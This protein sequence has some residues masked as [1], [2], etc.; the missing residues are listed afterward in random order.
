MTEILSDVT[1]ER[2][3][4]LLVG[5][6]QYDTGLR[7]LPGA[8]ADALGHAEWLIDN[9]VPPDHIRLCVSPLDTNRDH[10]R[11][12]ADRLGIVHHRAATER[13]IREV[14]A[15]H[16]PAVPQ[17][18]LLWLT[19]S[20]HGLLPPDQKGELLPFAD[21]LMA[22]ST[23]SLRDYL[24]HNQ[25]YDHIARKV[26]LY[27]ACR[28]T[29]PR[30]HT[31]GW[32]TFPGTA[33]K[34]R[35]RT[36]L[37]SLHATQSGS[38]AY[39]H[40]D[41]GG[42]FT[43]AFLAKLNAAPGWPPDPAAIAHS[44]RDELQG[45][46]LTADTDHWSGAPFRPT[47]PVHRPDSLPTHT[48]ALT[49][50]GAKGKFLTDTRLPYLPPD[51]HH[52]TSPARILA[53]LT[54]PA[55]S[56][57]YQDALRGILLTG[58]AG[59]GKTRTC[60][61]VAR[62]ALDRGWQVFH[63]RQDEGL[64][65]EQLLDS[66]REAVAHRRGS[67]VLLV[68]DYLD[69][70]HSLDL[71]DLATLLHAEAEEG[72][73]IACVAAVRPGA[74][75]DL[76]S[77]G[78]RTLFA[79]VDLRTD[80]TRRQTL[81]RHIF[82]T[83]APKA[84]TA[85]GDTMADLCTTHPVLALLLSLELERLAADGTLDPANPD[86]PRPGA[87]IDWFDRRTREDL[88]PADDVAERLAATAAA[89]TCVHTREAV[90]KSAD[91][92]LRGRLATTAD[93]TTGTPARTAVNGAKVVARLKSHGWLLTAE[94]PDDPDADLLDTIH[95]IVT[96]LFLGETC[97]LDGYTLDPDR[98]GE[99]LDALHPDLRTLRRAVG[100]LNRWGTDLEGDAAD[101]LARA[102][103]TWLGT[104]QADILALLRT[105]PDE[106]A[107]T[108][109]TMISALPWR[110]AVVDHWDTLV[111]PWLAGAEHAHIRAFL[112]DAA[113]NSAAAPAALLR[114]AHDWLTQHIPDDPDAVHLINAL[115]HA[116]TGRPD[117]YEQYVAGPT[118]DWLHHHGLTRQGRIRIHTLLRHTGHRP[119]IVTLAVHTAVEVAH[120][121]RRELADERLLSTL[122]RAPSIPA[123]HRFRLAEATHDWL[124]R[125]AAYEQANYLLR[126]ALDSPQLA[127]TTPIATFA[128]E[129]LHHHGAKPIASFVLHTLLKSPALSPHLAR[130]A[131]AAA[132]TWLAEERNASA[133]TASFVLAP[134]LYK[135]NVEAAPDA[136]AASAAA[137]LAWLEEHPDLPEASFVLIDLLRYQ[138]HAV[139]DP[140]RADVTNTAITK[141]LAWLSSHETP[142]E[143]H[144]LQ[145]LL[146]RRREMTP[147]QRHQAVEQALERM[148]KVPFTELRDS[149]VFRR[150]LPINGLPDA[151]I[152]EALQRAQAW[153]QTHADHP[154]ASFVLAPYL[155]QARLTRNDDALKT[156]VTHALR[157]L[158]THG[159]TPEA[160]YVI[161]K[162]HAVRHTA[163]DE[164]DP[165]TVA[166]LIR[167]HVLRWV[168]A[169]PA[170]GTSARLLAH[171]V[172]DPEEFGDDGPRQALD[173]T[174]AWL[175]AQH[176]T[177]ETSAGENLVLSALL[178]GLTP[179]TA[180]RAE[181]ARHARDRLDLDNP[182]PTDDMVLRALLHEE[183]MTGDLGPEL[184]RA[185]LD[186]MTAHGPTKSD[187]Q[188]LTVLLRQDHLP[189][190]TRTAII[191][192]AM[193]WLG[194][195][196]GL[197][198]P[199][200]LILENL[201]TALQDTPPPHPDVV[202]IALEWLRRNG[203]RAAAKHLLRALADH[204]PAAPHRDEIE[205][206]A[207]RWLTLH[208]DATDDIRTYLTPY[209]PG[210]DQ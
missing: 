113:L 202:P 201:I 95:D 79:V 133:V 8:A 149:Y 187:N 136:G 143:R 84:W 4:A 169:F 28:V 162:L 80:E 147:E 170:S 44:L 165:S 152:E 45:Q 86:V 130:R 139:T 94:D 50:L 198:Q 183:T 11:R 154:L 32:V 19:W 129:W 188:L 181:A 126:A 88:G 66:V 89:L 144:L 209:L 102:C 6:E 62:H 15:Q 196:H 107:R 71:R 193:N 178:T 140:D 195:D 171:A 23:D 121:F 118:R 206:H 60:L 58:P 65:A 204:P 35:R 192:H 3:Y 101:E 104:R 77:R 90:E 182:A 75:R 205:A 64:R 138:D 61:E 97:L 177:P 186:W 116:T 135:T 27:D 137:A 78:S 31:Y 168:Q 197:R 148:R 7:P 109:I 175:A 82:K 53:R 39:S 176:R 18:D 9:D 51:A 54:N 83:V 159:E 146:A 70:Y 208:P 117:H 1:P 36:E 42:L 164:H 81:A 194:S 67:R 85:L 131:V 199:G 115:A 99:L 108:L 155:L 57:G 24:L 123:D 157:W 93:G 98:P 191:R 184:I 111:T 76:E 150:L 128:L 120:Q 132:H 100:H 29:D 173:A 190:D 163:T 40:P 13:D 125:Y 172:G 5:I 105:N 63:P 207:A 153:L 87:L 68:L 141:A 34:P 56:T 14:L 200:A 156:G 22:M 161:H 151:L 69:R 160:S 122:L 73:H 106:G 189:A 158:E 124:V 38:A 55:D 167:G 49:R 47:P 210:R 10:V 91:A 92:V 127:D 142:W 59:T 114:A 25:A 2:T 112:T 21:G 179:G 37:L 134:L 185:I 48:E 203:H 180:V 41:G 110:R 96:D 145:A 16:L 52:E 46:R 30:P 43:R 74:R 17:A 12:A 72:L 33:H 166:R 119:D 20:G 26:L 174:R 103:S